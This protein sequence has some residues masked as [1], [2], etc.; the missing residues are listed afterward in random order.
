MDEN[1]SKTVEEGYIELKEHGLIRPEDHGFMAPNV[2]YDDVNSKTISVWI[3]DHSDKSHITSRHLQNLTYLMNLAYRDHYK[4][5][6][7]NDVA[8]GQDWGA[9]IPAVAYLYEMYFPNSP[10]EKVRPL[11]KYPP[12]L[13]AKLLKLFNLYGMGG[14]WRKI[15]ETVMKRIRTKDDG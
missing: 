9:H 5:F 8:Q 6:L 2:E 1:E 13:N 15:R 12:D 7:F 4:S 14:D 3:L 11:I 10:M